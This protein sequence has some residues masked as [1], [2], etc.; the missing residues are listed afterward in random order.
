[1]DDPLYDMARVLIDDYPIYTAE[2]HPLK[3]DIAMLLVDEGHDTNQAMFTVLQHLIESNPINQVFVVGDT[4]QVV[5]S[6]GGAD[7]AFMQGAFAHTIGQANKYDLERCW[8]FGD[9][10]AE[11]LGRHAGKTYLS[12]PDRDTL[13]EILKVSDVKSIAGLIDGAFMSAVM[14]SDGKAPSLAVVL[15]HPGC[16]VQLE[17]ALA[18]RG[19]ST[20][21]H[22]FEPFAQRP[23]IL[24][25]RVLVAWATG[26]I[27][28]LAQANFSYILRSVAEFTGCMRDK[29]FG[30]M[31]DLN[32]N[33][34]HR[35]FLGEVESFIAGADPDPKPVI[36]GSDA[37][38][39]EILRRFLTSMRDVTPQQLV[40]L[41][42]DCGFINLAR[43]AFVFDE[44]IEEAMGSMLDF[45]DSARELGSFGAWLEQMNTRDA[46]IQ[47]DSN[48]VRQ[49]LRLYSIP[50]AKGLEFDHIVIPDVSVDKFDG[51]TQEERNLFYVATS[52]AKR[53][54]TMTF[55]GHPSSFLNSFGRPE[56]W[57]ALS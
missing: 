28:T 20:E 38:A 53:K 12:N 44:Q 22:G 54:L 40:G 57:S 5:H 31:R 1:L 11:P 32:V 42:Q 36:H 21:S 37:D 19:Y 26:N 23:E 16:A 56:D 43:R 27:D 33:R 48:E 51:N 8:R 50:A 9:R 7:K 17:N 30:D 41:V 10:L 18:L 46:D 49:I 6:D 35:F 47:Q 39:L 4:D 29:N 55:T 25:L 52:R 13:V 3:L 15:R 45:A 34:F 24:F 2:N 14:E